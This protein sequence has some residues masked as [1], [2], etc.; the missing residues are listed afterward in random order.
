MSEHLGAPPTNPLVIFVG[1]EC[2]HGREGLRSESTQLRKAGLSVGEGGGVAQLFSRKVCVTAH[3]Q[4]L[5]D[6]GSSDV[7]C[8]PS[9]ISARAA[10]DQG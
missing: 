7:G 2:A 8:L 4:W 3:E 10:V 5:L 9:G 6:V 1:G